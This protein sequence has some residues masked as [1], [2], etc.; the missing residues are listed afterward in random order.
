VKVAETALHLKRELATLRRPGASMDSTFMRWYVGVRYDVSDG[1]IELVDGPHD[2]G[3]DAIVYVTTEPKRVVFVQTYYADPVSAKVIPNKKLGDFL[4]LAIRLDPDDP[5]AFEEWVKTT[6]ADVRDKYKRAYREVRSHSSKAEWLFLATARSSTRSKQLEGKAK[7]QNIR[8]VVADRADVLRAFSLYIE[9]AA[10]PE[11]PLE[12]AYSGSP[13]RFTED[14]CAMS[15]YAGSLQHLIN[16]VKQDGPHYRLFSRNVRLA[17]Q[18]SKINEGIVATA[19][20]AP[21]EFLLCHNGITVICSSSSIDGQNMVTAV[22]PSVVNGAQTLMTLASRNVKTT[23]LVPVRVIEIGDYGE[24]S[25]LVRSIVLRSNTQNAISAPDLVA[26]DEAQVKIERYFRDMGRSY[27]RRRGQEVL[28]KA[29]P[30]A[31]RR[32]RAVQLATILACCDRQISIVD[33]GRSRDALFEDAYYKKLFVD[34]APAEMLVK[35][36]I[37]D[38]LEKGRKQVRSKSVQAKS[39]Y[40]WRNVLRATWQEIAASKGARVRLIKNPGVLDV[41]DS[42]TVLAF[43]DLASE[44]YAFAWNMYVSERRREVDLRPGQYFFGR[45]ETASLVTDAVRKKYAKRLRTS[46]LRRVD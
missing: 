39:R 36:T 46:V 28:E 13:M 26:C 1:A 33:A 42:E 14:D 3:I 22:E 4:D 20:G 6:R 45:E 8:L 5:A 43:V 37:Y 11:K 10:P 35:A 15:I 16:Y 40:A 7:R 32:V 31:G 30:R 17:L 9:G 38:L 12:F 19:V 18:K 2:G 27:I 29:G 34:Q 23:A 24:K 44:M 41:R 21:S 25:H